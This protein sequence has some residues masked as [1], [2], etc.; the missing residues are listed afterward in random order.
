MRSAL[1]ILHKLP[2]T[3][4]LCVGDIMLDNFIYGDATRLSPEA[5]IPVVT[6]KR[7][8]SMP[9]GMGNVV[10]NLGE[11]G[12][13]PLATSITGDDANAHKLS[14]LFVHSGWLPP[15]MIR[16]SERPTIVKTRIIAGGQ[17]IVRFDEEVSRA[18]GPELEQKL[19]EAI[20]RHLGSVR[21]IAISDYGKG[22]VTPGLVAET[23]KAAREKGIPV[24]VDP[25]GRDYSKYAGATVVTP[26]RKELSEAVGRD[27]Q[28]SD[29]IANAAAEVLAKH[30]IK[31]LLVTRSEQGMTLVSRNDAGKEPST[32]T[33]TSTKT[34]EKTPDSS[35]TAT[36]FPA[37]AREVS[38]VSGAG[39]T[40][41]AMVA[42]ALAVGAPLVLAAKLATLAAGVV[43]GKIGT[44]VAYPHEI[45]AE[46]ERWDF[47]FPS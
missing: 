5:P 32:P 31:N 35:T 40:V 15:I 4:I 1:D 47:T 26:N 44:A 39:D 11:V 38:D 10:R 9:G 25:K 23:V 13:L 19:I 20:R 27:L 42:A 37:L 2:G 14:E 6:V 24:V 41:V 46:A 16:D 7:T 29:E 45:E 12:I 33:T 30:D 17:Q 21:A 3:A 36:T 34:L 18:I 28:D 22:I 43:V 8:L